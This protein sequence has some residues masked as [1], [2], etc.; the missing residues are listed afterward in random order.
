MSLGNCPWHRGGLK[1]GEKLK[2]ARVQLNSIIPI[3]KGD[4]ENDNHGGGI[5]PSSMV[6]FHF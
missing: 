1:K 4:T 2:F 5:D 3:E 6:E